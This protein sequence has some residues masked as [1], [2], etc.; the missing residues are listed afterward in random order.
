MG[1]TD[2]QAIFIDGT[3]IEIRASR[4]P[5]VWR[6]SMENHLSRVKAQ[7][8]QSISSTSE[9]ELRA[10]LEKS[11]QNITFVHGSGNRKIQEQKEWEHLSGLL[12]R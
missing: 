8:L 12:E 10:W 11:A 6:K 2:H 9:T 4:Y 1:Q 5:F 3:K 7:V